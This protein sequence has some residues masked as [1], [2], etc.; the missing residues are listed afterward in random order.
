MIDP[1]KLGTLIDEYIAE[2]EGD[3]GSQTKLEQDGIAFRL[4][5]H[6][7]NILTNYAVKH[8]LNIPPDDDS[9]E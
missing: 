5:G 4:L 3:T 7:A 9:R 2:Y 1:L 6:V 8:P